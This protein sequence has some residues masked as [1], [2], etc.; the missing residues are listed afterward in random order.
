MK[1]DSTFSKKASSTTLN[2]LYICE[3][4]NLDV[5][6]LGSGVVDL[7]PLAVSGMGVSSV[8][9]GGGTVRDVSLLA[10][11]ASAG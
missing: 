1:S 11:V 2:C 5:D 8:E 7:L 3:L 10:C 4:T 6:A 9:S